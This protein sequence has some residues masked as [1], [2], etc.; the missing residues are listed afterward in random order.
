MK[1]AL[2]A[3]THG[4]PYR[5]DTDLHA[6][7]VALDQMQPVRVAQQ[8]E[9]AGFHSIWFPDHVCMPISS[10]SSHT[11]NESGARAY[12]SQHNMLDAQVVMG[13]VSAATER[14]KLGTSCLIGPYRHPLSDARQLATIDV[15]SKGRLILGVAAGWMAEE[16]TALGLDISERNERLE[17]C[18]EIYKR[19]WTSDRVDYSGNHY[20]FANLSMD[21]KPVQQPRPP[22]VMG[23]TTPAGARRA[24]RCA[25]GIYPL[26]LDPQARPDRYLHLQDEIRREADR[27]QISTE[28]FHMLCAAS[29]QF[30]STNNSNG[31][32]RPICSGSRDE[33]LEDLA[34]F[35]DNGY[36]LVVLALDCP[37]RSLQ[38]FMEQIS[39]FGEEIIPEASKLVVRGEWKP[40]T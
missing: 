18:I 31:T 32:G 34:A 26:F 19:A 8:A 35:A 30:S 2:Y 25:D 28:H 21:P 10:D 33:I 12:A 9:T 15:L 20:Q 29:A 13:A 4:I 36:S 22:I 27:L 3:N 14:I 38:E 16:Y 7:P 37:S 23:A 40:V 17:E 39:Q 1:I 6:A 24:I 5:D 11:A